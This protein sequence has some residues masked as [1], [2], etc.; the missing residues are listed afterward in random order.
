MAKIAAEMEALLDYAEARGLCLYQIALGDDPEFEGWEDMLWNPTELR[1]ALFDY[2]EQPRAGEVYP[3]HDYRDTYI[4]DHR[5]WK[6]VNVSDIL[7]VFAGK[8]KALIEEA[9][10]HQNYADYFK[11]VWVERTE[12]PLRKRKDWP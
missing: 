7:A 10:S 9:Q 8:S 6:V 11:R 5:L 4:N 1:E 2:P 3:G 12:P